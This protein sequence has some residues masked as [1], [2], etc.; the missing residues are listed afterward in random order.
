VRVFSKFSSIERKREEIEKGDII[1]NVNKCLYVCVIFHFSAL[2]I[3]LSK[4]IF[5]HLIS[6]GSFYS[7]QSKKWLMCNVTLKLNYKWI[8][9][10][11]VSFGLDDSPP[12]PTLSLPLHHPLSSFHFPLPL[13]I[14]SIPLPSLSF[15]SPLLFCR[16]R[17]EK[18][19][20]DLCLWKK[21]IDSLSYQIWT[22]KN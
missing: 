8:S 10:W 7:V 19:N 20:F 14:P 5:I 16:S 11:I 17:F 6:S 3:L 18:S 9:V 2:I 15:V 22:E 1:V 4:T 21:L 13:P 12:P